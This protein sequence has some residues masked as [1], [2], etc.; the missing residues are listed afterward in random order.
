MKTRYFNHP[1]RRL[2]FVARPSADEDDQQI[3]TWM[4]GSGNEPSGSSLRHNASARG[5]A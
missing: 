4:I 2:I 5:F 3:E 1:C